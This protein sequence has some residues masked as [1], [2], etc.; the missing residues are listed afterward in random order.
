[1]VRWRPYRALTL[2][3]LKASL[4]NPVASF[5]F[6]AALML[7][8]GGI[9]YLDSAQLSGPNMALADEASSPASRQLVDALRRTPSFTL[10]ETSAADAR[11]RVDAGGSDI[12]VVI[13]ADFGATDATNHLLP[14]QVQLVYRAGGPGDQA[15]ALVRAAVDRVDRQAQGAPPALAAATQVENAG[16]GLIDVF[17]PGLL[18]FNVIQAGLVVAAG[19]F[20]TYRTSGAL[21]RVQVTGIAPGN[22]VLANATVNLLLG[23]VEVAVMLAVAGLLFRHRLDLGSMFAVTMLGYLVFLA[24]GF[25]IS[26]WVRDAQRAPAVASSVSL[27]LIF[28]GVLPA[29]FFP[30][31]AAAVIRVLPISLVTHALHQLLQGAPGQAIKGDLLALAGW[32]LVLLAAASRA[33]RWDPA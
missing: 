27:P 13:P 22:L 16:I 6:F 32:A 17:L 19:A 33:F 9:K 28:I 30:G 3:I 11:H 5:G 4:R 1:M 15:A 26:G 31:P 23:T 25:A 8:L 7:V 10:T 29:Q 12:A 21:R 24:A 2:A 20:A 14:A 18:G